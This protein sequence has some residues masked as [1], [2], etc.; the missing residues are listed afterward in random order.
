MEKTG[1]VYSEKVNRIYLVNGDADFCQEIVFTNLRY[2]FSRGKQVFC[3]T[4][5]LHY[6][7]PFLFISKRG[8]ALLVVTEIAQGRSGFVFPN[9]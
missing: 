1:I 7:F 9:Q 6:F 3:S 5:T 2:F 8:K 4:L